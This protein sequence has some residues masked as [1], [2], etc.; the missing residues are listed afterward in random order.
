MR[1]EVFT[2]MNMQDVFLWVKMEAVWSSEMLV[3]Y[4]ITTQHH[5]PGGCDLNSDAVNSILLI[6]DVYCQTSLSQMGVLFSAV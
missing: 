5:N 1:F 4:H 2:V 6:C 3:S